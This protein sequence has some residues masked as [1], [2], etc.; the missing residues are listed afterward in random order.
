MLERTFLYHGII[1]AEQLPKK[2]NENFEKLV[3]NVPAL[4]AL[5]LVAICTADIKESFM[6]RSNCGQKE[7]K[8]LLAFEKKVKRST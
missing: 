2:L 4:V 8:H 7:D 3:G 6:F 1:Y 5:L